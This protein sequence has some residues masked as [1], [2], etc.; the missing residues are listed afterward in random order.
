M[1]RAASL[2]RHRPGA[3]RL[4]SASSEKVTFQLREDGVAL[5]GLNEP[6]A[7]NKMTVEMG[8]AFRDRVLSLPDEA[9][10]LVLFGQGRAFSAGGDLD[11]LEARAKSAPYENS[12]EMLKFYER[13]L[14]VR[15]CRVPVISAIN[16]PA[17]GA[18]LCVA[19]ATD[20]RVTHAANKL[21]FSFAKLGLSPGMAATFF[22]PLVAGHEAAY[23]LLLTGD[24][25]DGREAREMRLV[26]E[27]VETPEDVLPAALK[28]AESIAANPRVAVE[29]TLLTLRKQQEQ[30]M[31][32][33]SNAL[34]RE[35]DAQAAC[36]ATQDLLDNV[37][38]MKASI[39]AKAAKKPEKK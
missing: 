2:A 7:L 23:R 33:M 10:C 8:E 9:R 3:R 13:F 19:M 12:T 15:K 6:S 34:A 31:I 36:Y 37:T 22:V 20:V 26:S 35:A 27:C 38:A 4:S 28:I 18:G 16:G 39:A 21:S 24:A 25:V 32:G 14:S 30:Y 1:R 29:T 17:V 11:F 5:L